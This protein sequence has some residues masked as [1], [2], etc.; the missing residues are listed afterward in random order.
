VRPDDR[1]APY[2]EELMPRAVR[3]TEEMAGFYTP[4]ASSYDGGFYTGRDNATPAMFH[5]TIGTDDL[6]AHR[7]DPM[8]PCRAEGWMKAPALGA[9]QLPVEHGIFNL[10]APG[11]APGRTAM[12]YRL[13]FRGTGG[14]PFTLNGYKD[15]GNDAGFDMW[16]DT[17]TLFTRILRGHTDE[18]DPDGPDELGRGLLHL[19]ARMF[20]RQLTTF[21]GDPVGLAI[22][23]GNFAG[24]LIRQ[25]ARP[26][27]R[28]VPA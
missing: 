24:S 7:A 25:Y 19:D 21:R 17:T 2:E 18:V 28:K 11:L 12:R 14:E 9:G 6:A 20:A 13:W 27:R 15:V 16:R 4:G 3:F 23:G 10:F 26:P 1:P 8:H 22:F 5:L